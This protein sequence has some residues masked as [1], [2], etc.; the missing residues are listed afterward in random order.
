MPEYM[1]KYF[2]NNLKVLKKIYPEIY[3]KV[4]DSNKLDFKSELISSKNQKLNLRVTTDEGEDVFIHAKHA[5]G[6]ESENYLSLVKEDSTG[7]VLMLGMGLGY[8]VLEL[9]EKRKQLQFLIVFELN[10]EFFF[11]ALH[12]ND[13]SI[14][15]SDP[16]TIFHLGRPDNLQSVLAPANR[17]MMLEQVYTLKLLTCFSVNQE[18]H[19]LAADVSDYVHLFNT[20]GATKKAYGKTF[21]ENRLNHLTSMHH[22][23]KLEDLSSRF[24]GVPGIIVAAGPSL[25]NNI[26]D[27][28]NAMGKAVIFAVDTALPNL[29]DHGIKP[30]FVTSIDYNELTYEKISRSANHPLARQINLI[31]TSWVAGSVTKQFPARQIFWGFTDNA[32][33][34]WI[35][36][37]LGGKKTVEGAGTVAHLNF[38]SASLMGCDP[39]IFVG[40]DLSFPDGK[41][42]ASNVIL[43]S[44]VKIK[45]EL[46]DQSI[47]LNVRGNVQPEV[48]TNRQMNGYRK[49]FERLINGSDKKVIN[50]TEGGAFIEGTAIQTLSA[51]IDEFCNKS[52]DMNID[53][54]KKPADISGTLTE[55]LKLIKKNE[56]VLKKA[57]VL[58]ESVIK[59]LQRYRQ[60][61]KRYSG[62]SELPGK[63]QKKI[64]DLD[65]C[66]KKADLSPLWPLFDDMTMQDL[67]ENERQRKAEERLK[68]DAD[69]YLEWLEK[70]V[71]RINRVNEIRIHNLKAFKKKLM[72]LL[73]YYL[74]EKKYLNART[75]NARNAEQKLA[76]LYFELGNFVLLE[77]L[78]KKC[79][80]RMKSDAD[81]LFYKG[82]I[83][84]IH[85]AYKESEIFLNASVQADPSKEKLI[86]EKRNQMADW[87]Y[88][89]ASLETTKADFDPSII[90]HLMIKGLRWNPGH[91]K[92][93]NAF[94]EWAAQ[95]FRNADKSAGQQKKVSEKWM[96]LLSDEMLRDSVFTDR[97]KLQICLQYGRI[98]V[99]EQRLDDAAE[100][101]Q[102]SLSMIPGN[103]EILIALTDVCFSRQDFDS[104]LQHLKAAVDKDKQ[105]AVYWFNMGKNLAVA[106]DYNGAI[107]AFEQFYMARPDQVTALKEIADCHMKIG[108]IDA[109]KEAYQQYKKL[110]QE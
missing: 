100:H 25:D 54:I 87:Y 107:F 70:S 63:V 44:D 98:L 46:S 71:K 23:R 51:A 52:V 64:S 12:H 43:S 93:S 33:E 83:S 17:A 40:Q 72:G 39:I 65:A 11:H 75:S 58:A 92:I 99:A 110:A 34:N 101:Y 7:V 95:D 28:K 32:L 67:G 74:K 35:N 76:V 38:V 19:Q 103:P 56:K 21:F 69:R 18:Y 96:Q 86:A 109:A 94:Q 24:E 91:E 47:V 77:K 68:G 97:L 48:I 60:Q 20:E 22:D 106:R 62:F 57:D 73:S 6:S 3:Q 36:Q 104:G 80:D 84:L 10:E 105:Y 37:S 59:T 4:I 53:S 66:N 81:F 27:L 61:R 88:N 82:F 26:A 45:K 5:P 14:F 2:D 16:R 13:F 79:R 89:M 8:S 9:F 102:Q 42:H 15:F 29:I 55:T 50:A 78:L 90:E 108:N 31:C 1:E 41:S 49:T 30:D 85:E